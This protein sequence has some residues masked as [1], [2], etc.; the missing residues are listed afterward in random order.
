MRDYVLYPHIIT[1]LKSVELLSSKPT[2]FGKTPG[3]GGNLT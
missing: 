3:G 1:G 2:F